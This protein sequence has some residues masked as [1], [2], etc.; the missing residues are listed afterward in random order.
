MPNVLRVGPY[1]I[2]FWSR[3]NN[4][5]P[6]V[7]VWR[8]RSVA[9]YWID[10]IVEFADNQGFSKHELT[11]IRSIVETHREQLLEAWHE[12]FRQA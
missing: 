7:H 2:G 11:T 12:H 4:E 10:P 9:K 3:E 5:P 8:D 1:R 6:H